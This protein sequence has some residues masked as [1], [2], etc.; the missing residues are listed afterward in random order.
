MMSDTKFEIANN[1]V[2]AKDIFFVVKTNKEA[3]AVL[4]DVTEWITTA[5]CKLYPSPDGG[6]PCAVV[7]GTKD[8]NY[9]NEERERTENTIFLIC[10]RV[11][12]PPDEQDVVAAS[13]TDPNELIV[14]RERYTDF[15]DNHLLCPF[16][17][18]STLLSASSEA[19]H[20]HPPPP[21]EIVQIGVSGV[22]PTY[23][24]TVWREIISCERKW[25][26]GNGDGYMVHS[27]FSWDERT[28][29]MSMREM[30]CN[31]RWGPTLGW[32]DDLE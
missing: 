21:P 11:W 17:I 2:K 4:E 32:E 23:A 29:Y 5:V 16:T 20:H 27:Q 12:D 15:D 13:I 26:D 8:N 9:Y 10:H 18:A 19:A 22:S 24:A 25:M 3:N 1:G 28:G 14:V 30:S 7:A 31:F 6:Y